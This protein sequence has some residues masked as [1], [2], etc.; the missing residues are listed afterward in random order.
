MSQAE[1]SPA[2]RRWTRHKIDVRL[3]ISFPHEGK[4][5]SAFGRANSLSQGGIGAYIPCSIPV[6]TTVGLELTF[7]YS[8]SEVRIKA[9]IRSCDGFRYG[10][11][12]EHLS[13]EAQA[14]I[15]KNC[16]ASELLQ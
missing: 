8:S 13:S 5:D 1:P 10:L 16:G 11:E 3:K 15:V 12:F 6:G 2:E 9:V 4:T 7:P 14:A